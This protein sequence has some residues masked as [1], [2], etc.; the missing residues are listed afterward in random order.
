MV[1]KVRYF[2][3]LKIILPSTKKVPTD[4]LNALQRIDD[5]DR[6][7]DTMAAHLL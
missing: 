3:S 7:A 2:L 4:I 5:V 1:A 6:L